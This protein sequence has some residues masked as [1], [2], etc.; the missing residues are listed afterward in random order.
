MSNTR[1]PPEQFRM[2]ALDKVIAFFS[3]KAAVERILLRAM[4]NGGYKAGGQSPS[5]ANWMPID[6]TGESINKMSR[7]IMRRRA[8]DAER[9]SDLAKGVLLAYKRNVVGK[10]IKLQ[11]RS[12][13][14][15]FNVLA[16]KIWRRWCK[17]ENCDVTGQQSM[18]EILNMIILRFIVDGGIL[19]IKTITKDKEGY[20]FKIQLRE[21]D[22]LSS[23]G[24]EEAANGNTICD[25]VELDK[26]GKPV[27]YYLKETDPNGYSDYDVKRVEAD[28]VIFFWERNRPSEYREVS[29]LASSLPRIKDTDDFLETVNFAHKMAASLALFITQKFPDGLVGGFGRNADTILNKLAGTIGGEKKV[30]A[31]SP[32]S[33]LE[34]EPGQEVQSVVPSGA[35]A[36]TRQMVCTQARMIAAGQGLSHESAS[37][38]VSEV[39]YSSARQNLLE[40]QKTYSDIQLSLI[41]KVLTKIYEE[42]IITAYQ[43]GD[44]DPRL[45][46]SFYTNLDDYLECEFLAQGMPWIDPNKDAQAQKTRLE[47]G[48]SNLKEECARDGKDWRDVLK[49]QAL[50]KEYK[51][52]LGLIQK[53]GGENEPKADEGTGGESGENESGDAD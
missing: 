21:V 3:P 35:A 1:N 43:N 51:E 42:V 34:L 14:E 18:R 15:K 5:R 7:E 48:T 25:G 31:I 10:G 17:A 30:E 2:N 12:S 4:A 44:I 36:E 53:G 28:R 8:R 33:I 24:M 20:H 50:E 38:D 13:D 41:E 52:E 23:N 46:P 37:R 16:E 11:A 45:Y 32:G 9:N 40:D 27:A 39:N 22:D 6:G 29:K 26:Y 19:I 47:N 49:Q